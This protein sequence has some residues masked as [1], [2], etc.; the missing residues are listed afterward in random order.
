MPDIFVPMDTTGISPYFNRV[1]N[2]GVIYR[3]AFD[4]SDKNRE[5]LL[6]YQTSSELSAYLDKTNFY[7]EFLKYS[8]A[9]GISPVATDLRLSENL[10]RVQLKAYI[11]RNTLDNEGFYPII[12]E[13]DNTLLK[14]IEVIEAEN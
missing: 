9:K 11:A 4:Y 14:A 8:E 13:I 3:F 2:L 5:K 10:I 6:K 7:S 1:R 12:Q